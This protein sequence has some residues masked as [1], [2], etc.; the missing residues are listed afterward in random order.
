MVRFGM[1]CLGC[2]WL[3]VH[4]AQAGVVLNEVMAHSATPSLSTVTN[5]VDW[6]E[7]M[8]LGTKDLELG[9]MSLSDDEGNP[10]RWVFPAG[11]R[12]KAGEFLVVVCSEDLPVSLRLDTSPLNTGFGLASSGEKIAIY[13]TPENGGGAIDVLVFGL[14][15]LDW[16]IGRFPDGSGEWTLTTPTA[17]RANYGAKLGDPQHL[18]INEWMSNPLVGDDYFEIY[19]PDP[20][21]VSLAGLYLTDDFKKRTKY[22]IPALSF[23]GSGEGA[24]RIFHAD[25]LT[26]NGADHVNFALNDEGEQL[27]LFDEFGSPIDGFRFNRQEPGVAHGRFPDGGP[28]IVNFGANASPELP[29]MLPMPKLVINEVLSHADE[30]LE[31]SIELL[32]I[33]SESLD[34]SGW[35]LSDNLRR[36]RKFQI[37]YGTVIEPGKFVTFYKELLQP[38][39]G[40]LPGFSFNS[41]HGDEFHVFSADAEGRL[42]GYRA[43]V[44]FGPSPNGLPFG[45]QVTSHG[46]QFVNLTHVTFG[47][48][49]V[50]TNAPE[51]LPE[52]RLGKGATNADPVV[53]PLVISEIMYHPSGL[54]PEEQPIYEYVELQNI[55]T[56]EQLLHDPLAI[57]NSWQLRGAVSYAFPFG[58]LVPP[59]ARLLV[60]GFDPILEPEITAK[61][62]AFYDVPAEVGLFG[63]YLGQ[64]SNTEEALEL[65][66]PD[67]PQFWFDPDFGYIPYILVDRISYND[68]APWPA[69]ADGTGFSLQRRDVTVYGN[70]PVLWVA[71]IPTAGRGNGEAG[72]TVPIVT[73]Q[74]QLLLA[75]PGSD[76]ELTAPITDATSFQWYRN[77]I[78]IDG[79]TLASLTLSP[80]NI[81]KTGRYSVL[82]ATDFGS[83]SVIFTVG[84]RM[85]P[86]ITAQPR[87]QSLS[88]DDEAAF[89]VTVRGTPPYSYQWMR[90]GLPLSGE[91]NA[92]LRLRVREENLG[93]YAVQITNLYGAVTSETARMALSLRPGIVKAPVTTAA[94]YG[95]SAQF[96]V[97]ASGA[98]PLSYQWYRNT[99]PILGA[100]QAV[101]QLA[102]V[103]PGDAALYSVVI[104]N[105]Y[106]ATR[107]AAVPLLVSELPMISI[108]ANRRDVSESETEMVFTLT[109]SGSLAIPSS[110]GFGLAG[111]A[112]WGIDFAPLPAGLR[113]AAGTAVTNISVRLLDNTRRDGDRNF[114]IILTNR[115]YDHAFTTASNATVVIH[116][117]E[118]GGEML[119][120]APAPANQI[121][122]PGTPATFRASVAQPSS[123]AVRLRYQW[124]FNGMDIPGETDATLTFPAATFARAGE[125]RVRVSDDDIACISPAAMLQVRPRLL[126]LQMRPGETDDVLVSLEGSPGVVYQIETSTNFIHWISLASLTLQSEMATIIHR[127]G[128][129]LPHCFYRVLSAP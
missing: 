123:P 18:R 113:I 75:E 22:P 27:G 111:S 52:Y 102:E 51:L 23:I 42:T 82:A 9:G 59:G 11:V 4:P 26:E 2:V 7:L 80:F 68:H 127:Q 19:N 60:V 79:G 5:V 126:A 44:S 94:F 109:R 78:A 28:E 89:F 33:S 77:G 87:M 116:D 103:K 1:A 62:R 97:K 10:R 98:L 101:L 81:E 31:D 37:P 61:F 86:V 99:A 46:L 96:E 100:D 20:S 38:V 54:V 92:V 24:F 58:V 107:S 124:Q 118:I 35:Y 90:D 47:T 55:T 21:P 71:G 72:G 69:A 108:T 129:N 83:V 91:T 39:P 105:E 95:R 34:L 67:I 74:P 88:L 32:N 125:Y 73:A 3:S 117:D 16:T 30:P 63:P 41:A 104:T 53:G 56:R 12:L 15:A 110:V 85:A 66:R 43:T 14:Q 112:V 29:N 93:A 57:T 114:T 49:I 50:A 76:L 6:V 119:V 106:G 48:G 115:Y 84:V 13:D 25:K 121:V 120:D 36:P 65:H 122:N 17:G 128:A 45:R 70:D 8:N 64:L 40:V